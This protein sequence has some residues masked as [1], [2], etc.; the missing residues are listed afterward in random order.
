MMVYSSRNILERVY[1]DNIFKFTSCKWM[2]LELYN[3]IFNARNMNNIRSGDLL[4]QMS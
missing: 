3:I 1:C 4:H 2:L